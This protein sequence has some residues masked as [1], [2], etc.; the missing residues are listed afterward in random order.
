MTKANLLI[1]RNAA[2]LD[3]DVKSK[4]NYFKY[5]RT[6][7]KKYIQYLEENNIQTIKTERINIERRKKEIQKQ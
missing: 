4:I 3:A 6:F 2:F 7:W 5:D 1:L